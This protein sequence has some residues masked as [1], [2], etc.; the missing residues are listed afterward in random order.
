MEWREKTIRRIKI[1]AGLNPWPNEEPIEGLLR[2]RVIGRDL[3]EFKVTFEPEDSGGMI[4]LKV[5]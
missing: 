5:T 3:Q 1:M 4:L 2:F